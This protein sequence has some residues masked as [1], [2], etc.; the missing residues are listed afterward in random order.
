M[1]NTVSLTFPAEGRLFSKLRKLEPN[2]SR[3]VTKK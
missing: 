1:S 2:F 3:N